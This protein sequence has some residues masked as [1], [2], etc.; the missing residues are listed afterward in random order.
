MT[1]QLIGENV[2]GR[3]RYLNLA[4]FPEFGWKYRENITITI[5]WLIGPLLRK[6]LK[7]QD[8]GRCSVTAGKQV[9]NIPAIARELPITTIEKTAES[10]VFFWFPIE[11]T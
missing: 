10:G 9:N 5:Q 1:E 7:K 2:D 6:D 11:A 3:S 8:N 4:T